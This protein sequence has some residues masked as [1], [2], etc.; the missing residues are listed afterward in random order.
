MSFSKIR[1][2]LDRAEILLVFALFILTSGMMF[3]LGVLV[4]HGVAARTGENAALSHSTEKAI[5]GLHGEEE[6]SGHHDRKPASVTEKKLPGESLRKAFRD[7]KQEAL[8]EMTLSENTTDKPKSVLD[9]EA[10]LATH[11]EWDRKPASEI[12]RDPD[13]M[14]AEEARVAEQ[15]RED[16]G[17]PGAVK[18]LFERKISSVDKFVPR[19]GSYTVQVASFSTIDE[20]ESKVSALRKAGFNEAY[21][22]PVKVKGETWYRVSVGS[23]VNDAWAHKT[24]KTLQRRNLAAQ[25]TIRQIP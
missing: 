13:A 2:H 7:S 17:V 6:E 24:G 16:S 8:V 21:S 20:A 11:S 19:S 22:Q 3:T 5:A 10:H 15:K 14:E 18:H 1:I 9:S 23:Y 12:T 4:G 25:Y